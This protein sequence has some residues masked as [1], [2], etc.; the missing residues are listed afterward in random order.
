VAILVDTSGLYAV[1]DADDAAHASVRAF[2]A[3]NHEALIV[4]VTVLPEI[5]YLV[6]TRLGVEAELAVLESVNK[7]ELRLEP[8]TPADL[9]RALEL[10]RRYADNEIGLVDASIVAVAERLG[11]TK[12]LTRDHRHFRAFRPRHHVAFEL[13]P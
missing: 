5:D 3:R 2:L 1:A 4:P 12:I 10:I 11:I 6:A 9:A 8:L 13:V 7:G